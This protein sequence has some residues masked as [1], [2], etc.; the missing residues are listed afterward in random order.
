LLALV[1]AIFVIVRLHSGRSNLLLATHIFTVTLGYTLTLLI[2]GL[3]ICFVSQRCLKGFS[4]SRL[5]SI[6]RVSLLLGSLGLERET[7]G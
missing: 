1:L 5:H 6:A 4:T 7:A 2:G 3:G